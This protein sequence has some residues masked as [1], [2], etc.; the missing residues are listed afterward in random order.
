MKITAVAIVVAA[1][2]ISSTAQAQGLQYGGA[3][4]SSCGTWLSDRRDGVRS[5]APDIEW[6]L[7]FLAGAADAGA[8]DAFKGTDVDGISAWIDRYCSRHPT[9]RIIRAAEAFVLARR[10]Q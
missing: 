10:A 7:G 8:D 5:S 1:M 6:V 9:E 2:F 3:G 4:V